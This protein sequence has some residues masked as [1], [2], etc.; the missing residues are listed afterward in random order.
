MNRIETLARFKRK[1][2]EGELTLGMQHSSGSPA[3]VELLGLAGW[4]FVIVDLEHASLT[5]AQVEELVRAAEAVELPAFVR[6]I[7]NDEKRIMQALD[8]GAVGVLVPHVVDAVTCRQAVAAARYPPEGTRGKSASSRVAG[9]GGGD[10]AAYERWAQAEPLV[11]PIVEDPTG[12]LVVEQI[13]AVE[14]LELIALGPGDLSAAYGE[15]T[16]G[17]RSEKVSAALDKLVDACRPRG[18]AVMTIPTPD[19][20]AALVRELHGRG[21]T[22]SWYGGD[23]N[24]L[25]RLFRTLREELT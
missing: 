4:D 18:I 19:M 21:V 24:H 12:V 3:V 17:I 1:V 13:A 6:V 25:A 8:A 16:L 7:K 10:W 9:W 14:G 2:A 20:D 5:I 22:V 15:A 11:I 23:L